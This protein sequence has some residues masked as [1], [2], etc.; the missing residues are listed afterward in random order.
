MYAYLICYTFRSR[1]DE[2]AKMVNELNSVL[3]TIQDRLK[4]CQQWDIQHQV[5][6]LGLC[7]LVVPSHDIVHAENVAILFYFISG[8]A[9][10]CAW[11][12][13]GHYCKRTGEAFGRWSVLSEAVKTL[14]SR[15]NITFSLPFSIPYHTVLH[16]AVWYEGWILNNA[17]VFGSR[18]T[19]LCTSNRIPSK[20]RTVKYCQPGGYLEFK[21]R[22]F[23]IIPNDSCP[24]HNACFILVRAG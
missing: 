3:K 1:Y 16:C 12:K 22:G 4:E 6:F 14:I 9:G 17:C 7:N 20:C 11:N 19:K 23:Q 21:L 5:I 15:L 8:C 13:V 24:I 10:Y 18:S 2:Q